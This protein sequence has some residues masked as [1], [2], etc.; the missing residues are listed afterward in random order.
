M[1]QKT[2]RLL[3]PKVANEQLLR[4]SELAMNSASKLKQS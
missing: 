2:S 4:T 3:D 1:R